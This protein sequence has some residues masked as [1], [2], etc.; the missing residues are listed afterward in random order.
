MIVKKMKYEI[1]GSSITI[2]HQLNRLVIV[3]MSGSV[4]NYTEHNERVI[5]DTWR[6]I[7]SGRF[8][9]VVPVQRG[10]SIEDK[11]EYFKAVMFIEDPRSREDQLANAVKRL[12]SDDIYYV[13]INRKQLRE[14]STES[15]VHLSSQGIF[16]YLRKQDSAKYREFKSMLCA[17]L[18]ELAR[19]KR[20]QKSLELLIAQ[21]ISQTL[22]QRFIK[23]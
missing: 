19:T 12:F 23:L 6:M 5:S 22:T 8:S 20:E 13:F 3:K 14:P 18:K 4:Q 9:F 1:I 2:I 10:D 7:R 11:I 21:S 17:R 15:N 16:K